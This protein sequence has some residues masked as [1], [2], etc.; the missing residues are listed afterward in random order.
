MVPWHPVFRRG[1]TDAAAV[2]A[3]HG[4]DA[5]CRAGEGVAAVGLTGAAI[6]VACV[7]WENWQS[8]RQQKSTKKSPPDGG[9]FFRY[10]K[11]TDVKS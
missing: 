1:D 5:A 11:S 2:R 6:I 9:D 10:K 8:G 7:V 4:A 3:A